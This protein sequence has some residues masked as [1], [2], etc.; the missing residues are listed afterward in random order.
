MLEAWRSIARFE[1]YYEVSNLGNIRSIARG[2]GR[3]TGKLLT[4]WVTAFGYRGVQLQVD[5]QNVSFLVHTLVTEAFLGPCPINKEVDHIDGNK[6][7]NVVTNLRYLTRSENIQARN[8]RRKVA[9]LPL[10]SAQYGEHNP[11]A[12]LTS[13]QVAEIRRLS[14]NGMFQRQIAECFGVRREAISKIVLGKRWNKE[15]V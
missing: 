4:C 3:R 8:E 15:D 2:Q 12:K 9:G 1:G 11:H 6:A 10:T 5:K 7:N 13:E 14:V